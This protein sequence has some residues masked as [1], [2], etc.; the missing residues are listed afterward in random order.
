MRNG[1]AAALLGWQA[2]W[3]ALFIKLFGFSFNV[4]RLSFS[5]RNGDRVSFSSNID[6]LWRRPEK[7]LLRLL[8]PVFVST[9]LLLS[10][11]FMTD[12]TGMFVV[13]L[14]VAK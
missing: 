12:V 7:C 11:S 2:V 1:C 8:Q 4:L 3:G 5:V 10:T 6:R 14:C 9:V 13:V